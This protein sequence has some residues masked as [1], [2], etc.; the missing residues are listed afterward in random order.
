MTATRNAAP[1]PGW[2]LR[3]DTFPIRRTTRTSIALRGTSD[4]LCVPHPQVIARPTES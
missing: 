3:L 4:V 1:S 2:A